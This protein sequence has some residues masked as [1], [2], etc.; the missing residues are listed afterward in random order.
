MRTRLIGLAGPSG[1][2]KSTVARRALREIAGLEVVKLDKFY[3]NIEEFPMVGQWRNWELPENLKFDELSQVLGDLKE[4]RP[5]RI[6]LYLKPEGRIV[7]YRIAGPA[8]FVLVEGFLLYFMP[9]IRVFFDLKLYLDASLECQLSRRLA[10]EV[11]FDPDYFEKVMK[12]SIM[13][14][15]SGAKQCADIVIDGEGTPSSVWHSF[16]KELKREL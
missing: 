12:P 6:P 8:P 7:G 10:R 2:G 13:L 9:Q 1:S 16:R 3:K 4:G 15:G 14:Y 5:A 11:D